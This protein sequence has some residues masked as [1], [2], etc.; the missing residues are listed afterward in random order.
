MSKYVLIR[1][2]DSYTCCH[3]MSDGDTLSNRSVRVRTRVCGASGL[4][5][6]FRHQRHIPACRPPTHTLTLSERQPPPPLLWRSPPKRKSHSTFSEKGSTGNYKYFH[7]FF[8][9]HL[10]L[11]RGNGR[12]WVW[13]SSAETWKRFQH[14][15]ISIYQ[16]H[17]RLATPLN[18]LCNLSHFSALAF[19]FL[20]LPPSTLE[21]ETGRGNGEDGDLLDNFQTPPSQSVRAGGGLRFYFWVCMIS[22]SIL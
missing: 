14:M 19:E 9:I 8:F 22:S 15:Y 13:T 6:H 5:L 16:P 17:R 18:S 7:H 21:W 12:S 10:F 11:L 1:S 3:W 2:V 4:L 20:S